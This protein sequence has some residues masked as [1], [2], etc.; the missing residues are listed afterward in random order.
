[1]YKVSF[2]ILNYNTAAECIDCVASV[3]KLYNNDFRLNIVI[4]DNNSTDD[5]INVI[6]S[7]FSDDKNVKLL[8]QE[9]N[10]GFSSGNNKGYSYAVRTY[11]PDFVVVINSDIIIEQ[12]DFLYKIVEIYDDD[13]FAVLGPDIY[14]KYRK[15]HQNPENV[16]EYSIA[17]ISKVIHLFEKKIED[18]EIEK[19]K[20][21]NRIQSIDFRKEK[22]RN[23]IKNIYFKITKTGYKKYQKNVYLHGSA[24]IFSR[25]FIEKN[26][27]KCFTP[28]VFYYGEEDLLFYRCLINKF[29]TVYCPQIKVIH[30]TGA[31]AN[32]TIGKRNE[33]N[34]E[35]FNL[36][37]KL[38]AKKVL[39]GEIRKYGE[40]KK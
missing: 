34:R 7:T 16:K 32:K 2:V 24:L 37:S 36:K 20:G 4:V 29:K 14:A 5:S 27:D 13:N 22:L 25:K 21:I 33:I 15:W 11:D 12:K 18:L 1:M 40:V 8:I 10:K 17:S 38:A 3:K 31:S 30:L 6:N 19:S 35:L 23:I 39:L 9:E 26:K 28:E